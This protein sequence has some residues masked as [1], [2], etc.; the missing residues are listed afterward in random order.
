MKQILPAKTL[1]TN[2]RHEGSGL[3]PRTNYPTPS[4]VRLRT[5]PL[6]KLAWIFEL[7]RERLR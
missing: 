5:S 1:T 7:G 6:K 3:K 4:V 2:G